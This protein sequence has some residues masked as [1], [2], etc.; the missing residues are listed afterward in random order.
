[1]AGWSH[2]PRWA[3]LCPRETA[4]LLGLSMSCCQCPRIS[5]SSCILES[6][7]L[8]IWTTE[9]FLRPRCQ[10][11]VKFR[12]VV[13]TTQ[14]SWGWRTT[15]EKPS[16]F[17]RFRKWL[18]SWKA[19]TTWSNMSPN[20]WKFWG[21]AS[22]E[23]MLLSLQRSAQG[24]KERKLICKV[25]ASPF[26]GAA[27]N[28]YAQYTA[29]V[30]ATFWVAHA[31]PTKWLG[32]T[33]SAAV[34]MGW[35]WS[36][37]ASLH[38]QKLL[39]LIL[40]H[41]MDL[42]FMA[43]QAAV[44]ALRRGIK[45]LGRQLTDWR[46]SGGITRR[47]QRFWRTSDGKCKNRLFG[48]MGSCPWNATSGRL[49]EWQVRKSVMS[50][51]RL[52]DS[53]RGWLSLKLR[54]KTLNSEQFRDVEYDSA[55]CKAAR[56]AAT[57]A[58][59]AAV[60]SGAFV[61]SARHAVMTQGRESN[62][63][64]RGCGMVGHFMHICWQC[65]LLPLH[66]PVLER[67][68]GWP[69]NSKDTKVLQHLCQIQKTTLGL[70]YGSG[71]SSGAP[72]AASSGWAAFFRGVS[73][74]WP[75]LAGHRRCLFVGWEDELEFEEMMDV[76]ATTHLQRARAWGKGK[77]GKAKGKGSQLALMARRGKRRCQLRRRNGKAF[78]QRQK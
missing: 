76:D 34:A 67:P 8:C 69:L 14:V 26:A 75:C 77:K 40:G 22:Q 28:F 63:C 35:V 4:W 57:G 27:R 5:F 61:F 65:P 41:T 52:G 45:V 3:G 7:K 54:E 17:A 15:P 31:F 2:W 38:L 37:E 56:K 19:M 29:G 11:S 50:W 74:R 36:Q 13:K 33:M 48:H 46:L 72:N 49:G 70:R 23:V 18:R 24:S 47:V 68:L 10:K 25:K 73:P 58:H 39:I 60:M 12:L 30:K 64:L 78:W 16:S 55:R 1:M 21:C 62:L 66:T 43:G 20:V 6:P 71:S 59:E 44:S 51:E 32:F 53:K 42:N 9:A